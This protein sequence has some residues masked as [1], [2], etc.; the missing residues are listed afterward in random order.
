M[1][2]IAEEG[3]NRFGSVHLCDHLHFVL[4]LMAD[5]DVNSEAMFEEGRLQ[6]PIRMTKSS[7]NDITLYLS[8]NRQTPYRFM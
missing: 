1:L 4:T 6:D 8:F 5:A 3:S 7:L 2:V